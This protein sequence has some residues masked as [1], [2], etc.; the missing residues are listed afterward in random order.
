MVKS[1]TSSKVKKKAVKKPK[2]TSSSSRELWT[3]GEK[4]GVDPIALA[5]GLFNEH[6]L[7]SKI[8]DIANILNAPESIVAHRLLDLSSEALDEVYEH[9]KEKVRQWSKQR[10]RQR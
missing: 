2:P 4:S 5:N 7:Y 10:D 1:S 6:V 3:P 8:K 9:L